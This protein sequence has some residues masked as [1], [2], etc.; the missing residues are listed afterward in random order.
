MIAV[1]TRKGPVQVDGAFHFPL[2]Y[3]GWWGAHGRNRTDDLILT[4]NVLYLL[5]YVGTG[6]WNRRRIF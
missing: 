4:K 6:R 2:I 3:K 1:K 5:S